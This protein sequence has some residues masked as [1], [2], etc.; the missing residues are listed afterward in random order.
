MMRR[1]LDLDVLAC[2]RCGGRLR[3][4]GCVTDPTVARRIADGLAC[5]DEARPPPPPPAPTEPKS[6]FRLR[7][8]RLRPSHPD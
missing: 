8:D 4:V 5:S 7:L 2:P 6:P 3:F 1:G